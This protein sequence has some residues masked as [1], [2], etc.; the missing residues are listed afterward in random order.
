M[1]A[2]HGLE[3]R[4]RLPFI[5]MAIVTSVFHQQCLQ[6][7]KVGGFTWILM[8]MAIALRWETGMVIGTLA[9]GASKRDGAPPITSGEWASL[10]FTQ[11]WYSRRR[12]RQAPRRRNRRRH[13]RARRRRNRRRHRR[14]RRRHCLHPRRHP[15]LLSSPADS[16]PCAPMLST[17]KWHQGVEGG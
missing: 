17:M 2:P 5:K 3:T 9:C 15:R 4:M 14:A 16:S 11:V 10:R 8:Q 13:R 7:L 12:R 6:A 1:T